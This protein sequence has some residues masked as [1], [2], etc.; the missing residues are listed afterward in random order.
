MNPPA[1]ARY[2]FGDCLLDVSERRLLRNGA[3]VALAP[4][5]FD[6]LVLLVENAGHLVEKD[7]FMASLWPDTFVGDD[8]LARNI[9]IL[10]KALG[11]TTDS[12]NVIA[13]V[14]TRGY[15]FEVA[16]R[17][18]RDGTDGASSVF[19][20]G[21][22]P[23][24]RTVLDAL[25]PRPSWRTLIFLTTLTLAV[26]A[27]ASLVTF[28]LLASAELP[29][30]KRLQ[31]ITY[32]GRVDPWPRL[33]T[34]G[35]S[36]YFLERNADHWN[37][38]RTSISGG[39]S[40]LIATPFKNAVAFDVSPDR[41]NLLIGSFEARE[42]RVPLWIWPVSGGAFRRVGDIT[43]YA[44]LWHPNGRQ[45][46]YSED[47]GVYI[48]D[49]DGANARKFA[50]TNEYVGGWAW[51]WSPDGRI[52]RFKTEFESWE[53]DSGGKVLRHFV[54]NA[55]GIPNELGGAW[56]Y[57]GRYFF[58]AHIAGKYRKDIWGIRQPTVFHPRAGR[59]VRLTNGPMTYEGMI[60]SKNESKLFVVGG[61][62]RW[63]TVAY[64]PHSQRAAS[65]LTG[66]CSAATVYSPD[67]QWIACR[68]ADGAIL[69]TKPD[70]SQQLALANASMW[71]FNLRWSP[72]SRAI[73]FNSRTV[74][75]RSVAVFVV[76]PAGDAP[77]Q[78]I[79]GD[80]QNWDPSW[81][82]DG[83]SLAL[84]RAAGDSSPDTIW[85][86]NLKTKQLSLLRGSEG[87]R[88]P[89]WSPDGRFIASQSDDGHRLML[90]DV[91]TQ[92]WA[93]L[94][95]AVVL[96][97]D[98]LTW[99]PDGQ[100]LYFQDLLGKNEAIYRVRVDTRKIE[101]ATLVDPLLRNGASR[102][103]LT[104]IAPEGT[105]ILSV[106]RGGADIYALDLYLP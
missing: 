84:T 82:P 99:S 102:V 57:D 78:V 65:L 96:N 61:L 73:A 83:E 24:R 91:H 81:S 79:P 53:T 85:I 27:V 12:Q 3:P 106:D 17:K 69:R 42:S 86:L 8:A 26:G 70:G 60:P 92:R 32:S 46:V 55:G 105:L 100:F 16:V 34:D 89:V 76:R 68:S 101:L 39:E 58:L 37:L 80:S 9:S 75:G 98:G 2:A 95:E 23:R 56:S 104:G 7:A 15:R 19:G 54:H 48:C 33:V 38:M 59:P 67:G 51:S 72:D 36:I 74:N 45:I 49:E 47:D 77:K 31:R 88:T 94:A 14:P 6:T 29:K 4:K 10:R 40:Q 93:Q 41:A 1:K 52:L 28:W 63:E 103:T 20:L 35:T 62:D 18:A 97:G 22:A 25:R 21:P 11:G 43:A 44:A 66:V 50:S 64:D 71:G 30:V 90:F 5:V 87:M 13:T